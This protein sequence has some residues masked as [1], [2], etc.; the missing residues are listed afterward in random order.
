MKCCAL[1]RRDIELKPCFSINISKLS[2]VTVDNGAYMS[3]L[4]YDDFIVCPSCWKLLK[5]TLGR[6]G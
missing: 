6:G 3:E 5:I 4:H 2:P 1:C